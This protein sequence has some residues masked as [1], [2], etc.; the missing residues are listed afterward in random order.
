MIFVLSKALWMPWKSELGRYQFCLRASTCSRR[1]FLLRRGVAASSALNMS[2]LNWLYGT[3]ATVIMLVVYIKRNDRVL[4]SIPPRALTFSP[5]RTTEKDT[6]ADARAFKENPI[7][8]D[9][10]LPPKTGR[11][12]I[13]VGGVRAILLHLSPSLA[14]VMCRL[15]S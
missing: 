6:R 12:Y 11:R 14:D 10:Q 15:G 13:V 4:S 9:D 5:V 8:V 2:W 3:L 7:N 1:G